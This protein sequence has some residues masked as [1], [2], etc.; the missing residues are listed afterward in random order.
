MEKVLDRYDVAALRRLF[1]EVGLIAALER[2]GFTQIELQ[3]EG[4]GRAL[5]HVLIFAHK[6]GAR[7]QL[8]DG[9]VGAATVRPP[10]F[11]QHNY[12][13]ER[14]VELAVVHWVR[15]EDPTATFAA[16]RPPLPLQQHPG[17]GVLR[18]VFRGVARI[19]ADL[20]MDGVASVPKFFHDAVIFFRSRLFLFLDGNE[21]GRFEALLRDLSALCLG[22]A[23]LAVAGGRV[24]DTHGCVVRWIPGYQVF[25]L[26]LALTQYFHS[27][28]YAAQV[29]SSSA[30]SRFTLDPTPTHSG[31]VWHT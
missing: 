7:F 31:G 14:S 5:P 24:R 21:Q 1:E 9:C 19:A 10:F 25:P 3:I 4:A 26:S 8:L 30:D 20:G 18:L 16:E 2:K 15:E 17:L 23:S 11:A 6:T 12:Q 13:I 28:Q 27:P 29:S 22:D